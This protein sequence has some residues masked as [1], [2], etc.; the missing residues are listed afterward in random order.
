[1]AHSVDSLFQFLNSYIFLHPFL[2]EAG[3]AFT[4]AEVKERV[5]NFAGAI[6]PNLAKHYLCNYSFFSGVAPL[7]SWDFISEYKNTPICKGL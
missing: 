6:G 3:V 1:M 2:M 7:S 4:P 5:L